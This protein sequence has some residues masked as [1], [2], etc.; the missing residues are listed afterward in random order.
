[1]NGRNDWLRFRPIDAWPGALRSD[2]SRVYSDFSATWT[3]TKDL[4]QR[5]VAHLCGDHTGGW[6]WPV[7][8]QIAVPEGAIRQDGQLVK[9][10]RVPDHPGVIVTFDAE[11]GPLRFSTDRFKS[12][13]ARDSLHG[14]QHNVRA[15]ALA[16]GAL[17][18]VDR[19]GLG[20]G[21]EQY[22]GF[23]ALGAGNPMPAGKMT[24]A[25]AIRLVSEHLGW[26]SETCTGDE[27]SAFHEVFRSAAKR[28]HPDVGGDP[29]LFALLTA[30]R[31]VLTEGIS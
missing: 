4:L 21:S 5:E 17:R 9:N 10:R 29:D 27:L 22:V 20:Q 14:W 11:H 7:V 19:Y 12:R 3:S 2:S 28:L 23:Q 31:D 6:W 16:L 24:R 1:M 25:E 26:H 30:A 15:I 18:K 13:G 8:L